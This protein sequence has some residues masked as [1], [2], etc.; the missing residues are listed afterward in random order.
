MGGKPT[1]DALSPFSDGG[2]AEYEQ[3]S[4][5]ANKHLFIKK[6]LVR[7]FNMPECSG[8]AVEEDVANMVKKV[9]RYLGGEEGGDAEAMLEA[10]LSTAQTPEIRNKF[11]TMLKDLQKEQTAKAEKRKLQ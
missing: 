3:L 2:D 7:D 9:E 4:E 8:G 6:L 10:M 1:V 5:Q 11:E